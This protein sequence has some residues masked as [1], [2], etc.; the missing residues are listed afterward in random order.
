MRA[1]PLALG[2]MRPAV[3]APILIGRFEERF[4][5]RIRRMTK[6]RGARRGEAE[7]REG[8]SRTDCW[9]C[10]LHEGGDRTRKG[11]IGG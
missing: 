8:A 1:L 5:P 10:D 3:E 7:G 11:L 9:F 6:R 2:P 4:R